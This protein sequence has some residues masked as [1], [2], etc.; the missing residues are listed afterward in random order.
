MPIKKLVP[1]ALAAVLA[2][3]F[4]APAAHAAE[5]PV[6]V[7]ECDT[8]IRNLEACIAKAPADQRAQM[9]GS[10]TQMRSAWRQA[11]RNPQS[12]AAL[13]QQCSMMTQQM[14]QQ[15]AAQGCEF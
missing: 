14:K 1:L 13:P 12:R 3:P 6:G 15:M 5:E 8:F 7:A 10:I 11:A 4:L 2:V 9:T